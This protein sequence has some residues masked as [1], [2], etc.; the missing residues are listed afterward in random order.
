MADGRLCDAKM[1]D[2]L[3]YRMSALIREQAKDIVIAH[4][5]PVRQRLACRLLG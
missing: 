2:H 3:G 4:G 1:G 5:L